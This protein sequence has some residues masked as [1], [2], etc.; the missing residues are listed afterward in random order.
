MWVLLGIGVVVIG[1]ALRINPLLVV[2]T[3]AI[4]TGLAAGFAPLVVI[5]MLGKTFADNR[6]IAMAWLILPVIGLLERGGIRER[7]RTLIAKLRGASVGRVLTGYFIIRQLTAMLGLTVLGGHVMRSPLAPAAAEG[8]RLVD[9]MGW[10]AA[11]PQALAALGGIFAAAGVGHMVAALATEAIPMTWP[12]TAIVVYTTG[13]ALFTIIMGNAFA[14]FPV[15][16]A[17]IGLPLIVGKFGGDPVIMSALGMLLG[18]CGT[19]LT[20]M[21]ANFNIVPA[22]ILELR[23]RN[24]V[25]KVQAPTALLLLFANTVLMA[26]FV[27]H[28]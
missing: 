7:A 15:M 2:T 5:A 13:M 10:A 27:I 4:V 6:F 3:S 21:A 9:A 25:I 19:L 17:G 1:F 11:L 22:A 14:A 20:P 12:L 28:R 8:R 16:T 26:L 18:F 24:A 23:D